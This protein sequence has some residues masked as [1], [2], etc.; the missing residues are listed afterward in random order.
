VSR[1]SGAFSVGFQVFFERSEPRGLGGTPIKIQL[2]TTRSHRCGL[3]FNED[4]CDPLY[5]VAFNSK[6]FIMSNQSSQDAINMPGDKARSN[7]ST[8]MNHNKITQC[9]GEGGAVM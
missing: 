7:A 4:T 9:G 6:V 3:C 8:A 2:K 1:G 5:D